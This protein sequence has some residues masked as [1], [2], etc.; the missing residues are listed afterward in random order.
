MQYPVDC[1]AFILENWPWGRDKSA[2]Y[3]SMLPLGGLWG[4]YRNLVGG[5]GCLLHSVS[6]LSAFLQAQV[7]TERGSDILNCPV[8]QR[9]CHKL[10]AARFFLLLPYPSSQQGSPSQP[11]RAGKDSSVGWDKAVG[12]SICRITLSNR[13]WWK[14]GAASGQS[15]LGLVST[16]AFVRKGL[17]SHSLGCHSF[18]W[19]FLSAHLAFCLVACPLLLGDGF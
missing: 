11:L 6:C 13:T 4:A 8:L 15:P 14:D 18:P 5:L 16:T 1:L 19:P 3:Y 2:M 9:G 10:L 17:S 7:D 12:S